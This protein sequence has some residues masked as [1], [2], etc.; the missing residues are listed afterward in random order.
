[1]SVLKGFREKNFVEQITLLSDLGDKNTFE[2][3]DELIEIFLEPLG[4]KPVDEMV[5]HILRDLLG[6]NEEETVKALSKPNIDDKIKKL[7]LQVI[8]IHRFKTASKVLVKLAKSEKEPGMIYD[9]LFAM[10]E[11]KEPEFRPTFRYFI[12]HPD[13]MIAGLSIRMIGQY[14]DETMVPTLVDIIVENEAPENVH[15]CTVPCGQSIEAL[16]EINTAEVV[17]F[18]VS[19]IHHKN[20]TARRILHEELV[21]MGAAAIPA[22]EKVY[23]QGNLDEK[24]LA[25][26]ILGLIGHRKGGEV[27][28]SALDKGAADH[29]NVRF[30]IFEAF[31][32]IKFM[33]GLV[34]LMDALSEKDPLLLLCVVTSLNRQLNPVV[35]DNVKKRLSRADEQAERILKAIVASKSVDLF[36]ILYDTPEIAAKLIDTIA[37]SNDAEAIHAFVERLKTL[38]GEHVNSHIEILST[39]AKSESKLKILAVDDSRSVISFYRSVLSDMGFQVYTAGNGKE[40]LEVI[41]M[42]EIVDLVI[43]DMNMPVMD[44]VELTRKLRT[45]P[46]MMN[47]P[48]IM[49]TTESEST[50]QQLARGAG[51]TDFAVKPLRI[52]TF[53][54]KIR[55]YLH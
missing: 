36:E 24:I 37:R 13:D 20:P 42:G 26:N 12:K 44:G 46:F 11:L 34:C 10:S 15:I 4:D 48:I 35:A 6:R 22:I 1:M 30:A 55:E 33:K 40:A 51:V 18:F 53:S 8:R 54:K 2:A 45:N 5:Q 47:V 23:H 14:S 49:V 19:K 50:Q 32:F 43:T 21:K 25:S 28:I 29:P 31:G 52:D 16:A 39:A 3:L 7:C 41:Q 17:D 27:M 38:D 9:I